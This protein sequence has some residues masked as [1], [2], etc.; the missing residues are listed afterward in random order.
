MKHK[1]WEGFKAGKW[2]EEISVRDFIQTN[3]RPYEETTAFW[4]ALL[5]AHAK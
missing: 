1:N 5:R 3:Y 2:Q 4:R